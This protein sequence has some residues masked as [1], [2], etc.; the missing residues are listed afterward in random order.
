MAQEF[1]ASAV[2]EMDVASDESIAA[3]FATLGK[4]LGRPR[5][6]RARRGIR[7]DRCDSRR[8]RRIDDARELPHRARHLQLQPDRARQGRRADAAR[9]RRRAAHADVSRRGAFAAELQRDGRGQGEP[10]SERAFPR[11]RPGPEGHSRQRHFSGP[12]QDARGRGH[13]RL[14]QDARPR[15]GDR[16]AAPQRHDRRRR[17]HRR[18]P[19]LRPGRRHHRRNRSTS[20]AASTRVGMSFPRR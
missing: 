18:V 11:R 7:A 2:F 15:R 14:P 5:H 20:T 4:K 9:P 6:R 19:V 3:G 1:G 12:D 16:A 17:Q 13:R 10:G 8:L